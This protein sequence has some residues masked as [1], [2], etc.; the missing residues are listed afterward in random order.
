MGARI[1]AP[2]AFSVH[3]SDSRD[4]P[5]EFSL[6]AIFASRACDLRGGSLAPKAEISDAGYCGSCACCVDSRHSIDL[7]RDRPLRFATQIDFDWTGCG[8]VVSRVP[9]ARLGSSLL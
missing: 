1:A 2:C 4:V 6:A 3:D 8:L 7:P 5:L 9:G